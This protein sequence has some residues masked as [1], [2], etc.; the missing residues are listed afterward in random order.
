MD[1]V[2]RGKFQR[3]FKN[4]QR[5]Y[6]SLAEDF[7]ILKEVLAENPPGDGSSKR[8]VVLRQ[9][10]SKSVIKTRMAC[11]SLKK[12]S[13]RVIYYYDGHQIEFIFLE[14]YYK[15]DKESEDQKR[16]ADFWKQKV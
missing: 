1:F 2:E 8:R 5:R 13:L 12:R 14:I 7:R 4:L 15:G 3:E 10:G 6:N 11:R 9:Q 16:I